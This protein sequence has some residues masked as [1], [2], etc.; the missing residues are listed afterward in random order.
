MAVDPR[1]LRSALIPLL[2][3]VCVTIALWHL[4]AHDGAPAPTRGVLTAQDH[5]R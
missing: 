3:L 5:G 4:R 2:I 1:V